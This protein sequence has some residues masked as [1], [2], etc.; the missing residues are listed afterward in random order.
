MGT[1]TKALSL[2]DYFESQRNL[3]GLSDMSRLSGMNKATVYRMMTEL[4]Q[5]GYVEQVAQTRNYRLG[6][7]VLRLARLREQAV[8]LVEVARPLLQ[9]LCN[10]TNETAHVSVVIGTRLSTVAHAYSQTHA[11]KVM[12]EDA[13]HL[14]FHGTASGLSILGFA[15]DALVDAVLNEPLLAHTEQTITEAPQIRQI[16]KTVRECGY[17]VSVGGFEREVHSFAAPVMDAAGRPCGAIAVAAPMNRITQDVQETF[18]KL[19]MS[20]A[21]ELT[22]QTGGLVK[23]LH[24]ASQ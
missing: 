23:E 9:G 13:E 2:L 20:A 21:N 6:P 19:V 24:H 16:L 1:V 4:Q 18:P 12:M 10:Q 3:I 14:S 5:A 8:P 17:A 11:T 7:T 15:D 22:E